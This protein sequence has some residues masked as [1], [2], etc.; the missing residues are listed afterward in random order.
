VRT[1]SLRAGAEIDWAPYLGVEERTI[2]FNGT[3]TED[4]NRL[5]VFARLR[6]SVG[7]PF[8]L[9]LSVGYVPPIQMNHVK[10][11]LLALSLA[12][13]IVALRRFRLGARVYGQV[14]TIGGDFTCSEAEARAGNDPERNSFGC[15]QRS[16]DH[17]DTY[18]VG[19]ELGA[20]YRIRWI[21]PYVTIAGNYLN[22]EFRISADYRGIQDRTH[23]TT[24][25]P[26][27][28]TTGGLRLAV[29]H[30]LDLVG[31]LFYSPLVIKRSDGS[32]VDGLWNVRTL[33]EFR[34]F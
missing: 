6:L 34:F 32:E 15:E 9:L 13:P 4:V 22:N 23:L 2:G 31:E 17:L 18:Y 25:G 14:G 16:H 8:S 3:K 27:F 21:E 11:H 26:T 10:A 20:A 5:P 29:T 33:I 30:K 19:L 7:L 1:G 12:R 28:S 24:N